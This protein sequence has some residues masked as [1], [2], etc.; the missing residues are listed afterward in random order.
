[1]EA[2]NEKGQVIGYRQILRLKN[3][4]KIVKERS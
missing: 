3:L 1:M 4:Q 2:K